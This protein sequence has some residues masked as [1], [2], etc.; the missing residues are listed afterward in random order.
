MRHLFGDA[1]LLDRAG[2]IAA[3]DDSRRARIGQ[4]AREGERPLRELGHLEDAYGSVPDDE[5]GSA[6]RAFVTLERFRPDIHHAPACGDLVHIHHPTLSLRLEL[7]RDDRVHGQNQLVARFRQDAFGGFHRRGFNETV[8]HVVTFGRQESVRHPAADDETVAF[9]EQV[10]HDRDLVADLR[11]AQDGDVGM[12]GIRYRTSE[13]FQFLFHQKTGDGRQETCHTLGRGMRA[14]R[15]TECVVH[16]DFAERG[17]LFRQVEIVL[18]LARMEARIFEH[19]HVTGLERLRH[20]LHF[21]ANAIRRHLDGTSQQAGQNFRS[22]AQAE[23]G[24]GS[25]FW[26]PKV[27]HQ[28]ERRALVEHVLDGRQRCFDALVVGDLP[29]GHRHVEVH[30]HEHAFVFEVNVFYGFFV[31]WDSVYT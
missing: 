14:V 31:H 2:G 21:R 22:G 7:V 27:T 3:A 6:Q 12:F 23:Y 1:R 16:V 26:P 15:R 8:L 13:I 29:L 25:A 4:Q 20:L 19:Q 18:F 30:A 9:G 24:I 11:A 10:F 28:E 5:A 17:H